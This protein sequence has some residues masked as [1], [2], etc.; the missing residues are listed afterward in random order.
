MR[1]ARDAFTPMFTYERSVAYPMGHRN[2]MF[3]KRGVRTLP[4]LRPV[5]RHSAQTF[6][7]LQPGVDA[8]RALASDVYDGTDPLAVPIGKGL[9]PKWGRNGC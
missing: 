1:H 5:L 9:F 8:L 6:P 3:A 2:C 7:L 4:R